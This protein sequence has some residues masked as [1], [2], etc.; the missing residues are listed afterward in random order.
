MIY[1]FLSKEEK[2]KAITMELKSKGVPLDLSDVDGNRFSFVIGSKRLTCSYNEAMAKP[3]KFVSYVK[4]KI[5][6]NRG[7]F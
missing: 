2:L 7:D 4:R 6:V 5:K 1:S 3:N